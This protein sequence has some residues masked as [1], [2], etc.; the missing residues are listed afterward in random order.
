MS[1]AK[2]TFDPLSPVEDRAA[3]IYF[4]HL[5]VQAEAALPASGREAQVALTWLSAHVAHQ[6]ARVWRA[7]FD[8][9][10]LSGQSLGSWVITARLNPAP[11]QPIEIAR[12]SW[13][14][15][16]GRQIIALAH[17]FIL[18]GTSPEAL[19]AA[20]QKVIDF[21]AA[22][23][24]PCVAKHGQPVRIRDMSGH[25]VTLSARAM[26]HFKLLGKKVSV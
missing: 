20:R 15:E 6:G 23:L 2:L 17:P 16:D 1:P 18:G 21:S 5:A 3:A 14:A 26:R 12:Q 19:E 24:A 9:L 11:K 7:R 25:E 13:L 8:D 10:V 4:G 22:L